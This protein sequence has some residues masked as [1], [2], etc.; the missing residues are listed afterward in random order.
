MVHNFKQVFFYL[1]FL[2]VF[3]AQHSNRFISARRPAANGTLASSSLT[4][5]NKIV[6]FSGLATKHLP[7]YRAAAN[8]KIPVDNRSG[9]PN[10]NAES[11]KHDVRAFVREKNLD[12]ETGSV[13]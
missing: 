1:F 12:G 9:F 2:E 13:L 7:K 5:D 4:R 11:L 8:H 6:P 3:R 10:V